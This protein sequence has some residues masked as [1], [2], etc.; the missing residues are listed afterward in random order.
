MSGGAWTD[1]ICYF[2]VSQSSNIDIADR[3]IGRPPGNFYTPRKRIDAVST[4]IVLS[5]IDVMLTESPMPADIAGGTRVSVRRRA[6][7]AL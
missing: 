3:M 1:E 2:L 5:C 7:C 4:L 6:A